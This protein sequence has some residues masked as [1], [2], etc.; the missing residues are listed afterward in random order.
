MP[1]SRVGRPARNSGRFSALVIILQAVAGF[2]GMLFGVGPLLS[3]IVS[4]LLIIPQL[5][6]ARP[7]PPRRGEE[8]TRIARAVHHVPGASAGLCV[9]RNPAPDRRARLPG[10]DLLVFANLLRL[11]L[12]EGSTV[13]NRYGGAPTP[14]GILLR[15]LIRERHAGFCP[16]Y[17]RFV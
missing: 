8:R 5:A 13:P 17:R 4:A 14:S 9:S 2:V 15:G 12:K 10:N 7:S 6:V 16:G 3:A 1:T 11:F